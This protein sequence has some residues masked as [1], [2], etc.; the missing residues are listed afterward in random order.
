VTPRT[1]LDSLARVLAKHTGRALDDIEHLVH[2]R[3][4]RTRDGAYML[5]LFGNPVQGLV[6]KHRQIRITRRVSRCSQRAARELL[7]EADERLREYDRSVRISCERGLGVAAL[8]ENEIV[9][10]DG[11]VYRYDETRKAFLLVEPGGD[12]EERNND[13]G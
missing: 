6:V 5:A 11:R 3:G 9:L 2:A 4:V 1:N 10:A 13:G 7:V 8:N 12:E